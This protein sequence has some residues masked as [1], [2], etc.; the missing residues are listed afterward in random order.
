VKRVP[1]GLVSGW[2]HDTVAAGTTLEATLPAGVFCLRDTDRPLVAFCGGSGVTPV[3]SLVKSALATTPR[4]IAVYYANRT[5]GSVIFDAELRA[6]EQEHAE[7]LTVVRHDDEA[8]GFLDAE[9]AWA[10]AER[11]GSDADFY[12]CGPTPFMDLVEHALA[13]HGV[14]KEHI[15][16][17][18]FGPVTPAPRADEDAAADTTSEDV[19]S[20]ITIVIKRKPHELAYVRGE[21]VLE[22]ARRG[23]LQ[24][25]Y[26]CEAGNCATCMAKLVEGAAHMR[27]NNALTDDEVDEGWI[28]TCQSELSGPSAVVEYEE[29]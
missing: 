16:V 18:R 21:T 2:F 25:P 8:A 5:A 13:A 26:S 3:M 28:L 22:T 10:F 20:T 7:R 23:G 19:P 4:R 29:L 12:L 6:L 17:E 9:G 15:F 11:F 27:A 1:G 24:T 14:T